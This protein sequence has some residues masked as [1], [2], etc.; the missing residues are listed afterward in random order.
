MPNHFPPTAPCSRRTI[1]VSGLISTLLPI[2]AKAQSR[3]PERPIT[4]VVPFAAGGVAD[5]TA[6]VVVEAMG[7]TLG[8]PIVVDNRPSA[9]SITASQAV[10][11][12]KPD[13]HTLLLVSNANAVSVSLFKKLPYDTVKDFTPI[14]TLGYFDLGIFVARGSRFN[15]LND[16]IDF[17][18]KNPGKLNIATIAIGSTQ[19]LAAELFKSKAGIDALTIPF[20]AS[21]AAL[22]ALRAGEVDVAIEILAPMVPHI[23]SGD[24]RA[25]AVTGEKT[26]PALPST[27]TAQQ[28]GLI[29]FNVASWNAISAPAGT[30]ATVVDRLNQAVRDALATP[31]VRSK[32]EPLGVRIHASTPTESQALL[33]SEIKRWGDVIR[34]G[35][36]KLD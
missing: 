25:L 6:R 22:I 34:A 8:Q 12:A 4:L 13:G 17:G 1:V 30:P 19:H 35:K 14:S 11:G 9:G 20:K 23:N 29:G 32:L 26:N 33:V 2:S 27:L 7:R 10:A 15:S 31:A 18:K 28:A 36:I 3:Y 16:L 24:V 21:S 5:V